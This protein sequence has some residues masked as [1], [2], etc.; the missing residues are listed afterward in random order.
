MTRAIKLLSLVAT[1]CALPAGLLHAQAFGTVQEVRFTT[2]FPFYVSSQKM[3][4][5]SYTVRQLSDNS[6]QL[7][8]R[9]A[10]SSHSAF[11]VYNAIQSTEP[12]AHGKVTFHHYGDA[13]YYLSGLTLTGEETVVDIPESRTEK[14]AARTERA[15]TSVSLQVIASGD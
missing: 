11:V 12:V 1:I 9:E 15:S 4:A 7:L 14:R 5:G 3:P 13:D 10:D 8:I 6:D 2:P